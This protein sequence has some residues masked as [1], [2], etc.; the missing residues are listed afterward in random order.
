[1]AAGWH[2]RQR[3]PSGR[4]TKSR[5]ARAAVDSSRRRPT[6][7]TAKALHSIGADEHTLTAQVTQT[8]VAHPRGGSGQRQRAVVPGADVGGTRWRTPPRVAG[9]VRYRALRAVQD[10]AG[11]TCVAPAVR[12]QADAA[13]PGR[14]DTSGPRETAR[15]RAATV[16]AAAPRDPSR[17]RGSCARPTLPHAPDGAATLAIGSGIRPSPW[18]RA[19]RSGQEKAKQ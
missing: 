18:A 10:S 2:V 9:G 17:A 8:E 12:I 3:L 16:S 1:M 19:G 13:C 11:R 6:A 4:A 5:R 7:I 14:S 15:A